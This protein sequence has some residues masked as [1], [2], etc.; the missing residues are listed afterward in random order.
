[1]TSESSE[2]TTRISPDRSLIGLG[3]SDLWKYRELLYF[4]TLRDI[5]VRY[6]QTLIGVLWAVLQ[7]ALTTIIFTVIFSQVARF[8]APGVPY[9]VFVLSGLLIWLF[10]FN[11][12][13]FASNSLVGNSNLV[14][15]V[16]FPR[17]IVPTAA[18]LAGLVDLVP[19]FLMLVSLMLY[20]SAPVSPLIILAPLFIALAVLLTL[21]LGCLLSALNV[22][23]RDVKF[24]LPFALQVWM[25]ASPVFYPLEIVSE[26]ARPFFA[27]N[28]LTGILH[29]FRVSMFGGTFDWSAIG[30]SLAVTMLLMLIA[31]IVFRKMEDDF[32]DLI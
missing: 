30:V 21:S 28:P 15:K 2:I 8:D 17:L 6:K 31:I 5:K 32:A 16:F 12:V 10:T 27:I 22:R 3:L 29:G 25:F 4:L 13:T 23:F 26:K 20:Y 24:A 14:T 1:M 18:T 19:G 9:P 7:P 11:S